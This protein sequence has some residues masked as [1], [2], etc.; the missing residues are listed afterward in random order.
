[1]FV[2]MDV[3]HPPPGS[4]RPSLAAVVASMDGRMSQFAVN[5]SSQQTVKSEEMILAL[6]KAMYDLVCITSLIDNLS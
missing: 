2:G 6:D 4:D 3:S 1:M 5:L